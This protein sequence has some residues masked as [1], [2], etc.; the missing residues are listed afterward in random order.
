LYVIFAT[1]KTKNK[2]LQLRIFSALLCF[3]FLNISIE[4]HKHFLSLNSST[5]SVT[6]SASNETESL[7]NLVMLAAADMENPA[8]ENS[9]NL[10]DNSDGEEDEKK[11]TDDEFYFLHLNYFIVS[12]SKNAHRFH[13][14]SD[15]KEFISEIIPPPPKA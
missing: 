13:G 8:P 6:P 7:I 3:H 2:T 9:T 5:N 4:T 12:D 15:T 14:V 10:P 11:L 1:V